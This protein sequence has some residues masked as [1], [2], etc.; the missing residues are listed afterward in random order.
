MKNLFIDIL[1]FGALLSSVLVITSK[2]PVIAVIFLISVFINAAGY[3]I[4]LGIGFI[5]ISYIV[6]YVGAIAVLFLF[7]IMLINIR[8]TDIIETGSQYTKNIPLALGISLLF[9]YEFFTIMPF[10]FNNISIISYLLNLI[11]N[12]NTLMLT[13][14]ANIL[15]Y[16]VVYNTINPILAVSTFTSFTQIQALGINL[17]TFGSMWLIIT[18]VILLLAMIAPICVS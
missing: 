10:S 1:A 5:G 13:N 2:N 3:L 18:S 9:V 15:S 4:L 7:V 14:I 17:Y 16:N 6:I 8:L 12:L 11:N